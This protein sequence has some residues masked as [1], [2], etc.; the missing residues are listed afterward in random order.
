MLED[1]DGSATYESV[2]RRANNWI[3]VNLTGRADMDLRTMGNGN[4]HEDNDG[5]EGLET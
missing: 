5:G 3:L 4:D 2:K 1:R